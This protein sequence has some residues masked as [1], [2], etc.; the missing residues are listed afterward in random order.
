M[1]DLLVQVLRIVAKVG[2]FGCIGCRE[3]EKV[4]EADLAIA[5]EVVLRFVCCVTRPGPVAL[6]K[7]DEVGEADFAV[8]VEVTGERKDGDRW[9]NNGKSHQRDSMEV[10]PHSWASRQA[11]R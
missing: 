5:I 6:G 4:G 7:G 8:T 9:Q 11:T 2:R 10:L 3:G 1:L